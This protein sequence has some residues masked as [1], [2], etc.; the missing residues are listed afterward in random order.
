MKLL[1]EPCGIWLSILVMHCAW[2]RR[3]EYLLL[4]ICV[5]PQD[6]KWHGLW[7]LWLLHTCLMAGIALTSIYIKICEGQ[8]AYCQHSSSHCRLR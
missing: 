5:H 1:W 3:K 7:Q 4:Y 8:Y 6:L 2:W